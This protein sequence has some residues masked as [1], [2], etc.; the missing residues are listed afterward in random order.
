MYSTAL[1]TSS[2]TTVGSSRTEAERCCRWNKVMKPSRARA[3]AHYFM[4]CC[5]TAIGGLSIA[6]AAWDL[7]DTFG[8]SS[9]TLRGRDTLRKAAH[10]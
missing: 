1:S 8:S 2:K 6:A 7:V 3:W 10:I 5:W 9:E 4:A